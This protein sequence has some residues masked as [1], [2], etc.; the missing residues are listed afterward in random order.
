VAIN[1]CSRELNGGLLALVKREL[2]DNELP[3]DA[4][5]IEITERFLGHH[6]D[7][8]DAM[9]TELKDLGVWITLDDFGTGYSSLARLRAFPVDVL[10][11]DRMFIDELPENA[12]IADSIIGLARNLGLRV[13]AEGVENQRQYEWLKQSGCDAVAGYLLCR[14]QPPERLTAWLTL[15]RNDNPHVSASPASA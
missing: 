8:R 1:S 7:I 12:A 2:T 13:I 3:G 11:I 10:K 15:H 5:E 14:P 6:D 4:L 9:L